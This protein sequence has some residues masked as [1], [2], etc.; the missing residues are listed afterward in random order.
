M[1]NRGHHVNEEE[2]WKD[3][4]DQSD[5][6]ARQANIDLAIALERAPCFPQALVVWC[7]GEGSFLLA[8]AW[9]VKID[10]CS[11]LGFDLETLD[12]AN[13]L[14][15]LLIRCREVRSDLPKI[16][17]DVVLHVRFFFNYN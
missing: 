5:E 16:L 1:D 3:G 7:C 12:H 6:V 17:V 10:S 13:D 14:A 11:K 9:D 2:A 15:L 4:E 8:E